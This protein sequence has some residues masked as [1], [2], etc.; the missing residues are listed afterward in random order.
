M[1]KLLK[2]EFMKVKNYSTF[3]AILIMYACLVPITYLGISQL[4]I[5]LLPSK[6]ALLSFPTVWHYFTWTAS[7]WNVLL[8]VLIVILVCNEYSFKTQRQNVIDGLSKS[9]MILSKFIFIIALALAVSLYAFIVAAITGLIFNG[10]SGFENKIEYVPIYGLQ[11][12][13]Y[14]AFAFLLATLVKRPALSIILY[15]VVIAID[16][17]LYNENI[18]DH[19]AQF[20]PTITISELTPNPF[21]QQLITMQK[22]QMAESGVAFEEP[23]NM[24]QATRSVLATIYIALLFIG[25]YF[26]VKRRDI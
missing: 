12:V 13:G 16:V 25:S 18:L 23:P 5:N 22:M 19:H 1:I 24:N 17:F 21:Y 26:V 7:W 4:G 2:I 10:P 15:I 8:G 20:F 14:F 6:S 9:E 3:W 11:T